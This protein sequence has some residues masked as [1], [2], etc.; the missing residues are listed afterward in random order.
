MC[1][2][3]A[4]GPRCIMAEP[5]PD[6]IPETLNNPMGASERPE[7]EDASNGEPRAPLPL[8]RGES[9]TTPGPDASAADSATAVPVTRYSDDPPTD[10]HTE[11]LAP[12]SFSSFASSL[13]IPGYEI[14][15]KLGEG[16]M[17]V[18]YRARQVRANR[19]VALKMVRGLLTEQDRARFRIEAESV[20]RLKHD[21]IV[22]IYEIGEHEDRPYFSLEFCVGG[23]L[24]EQLEKG[25]LLPRLAA[26]LVEALARAMEAAHRKHVVHRDLKPANVLIDEKGRPK[27]S[28]FGLAK[29][30]D[31]KS[32]LTQTNAIMGT[33]SYMAPE[34]AEGQT[35]IV[36]P[37]ADVY[38]LGAIL[39]ECLTGRPPFKGISYLDTLEQV[40]QQ[41]PTPPR[42]LRRN[43][44]RDLE[45]ICLHCLKKDPAK[46]YNSAGD[47]AEDLRRFQNGESVR[48][49]RPGFLERTWRWLNQGPALAFLLLILLIVLC[50]LGAVLALVYQAGVG[51]RREVVE[52]QT[53]AGVLQIAAQ[54]DEY[55]RSYHRL[56]DLYA[57]ASSLRDYLLE[58]A[59]ERKKT[60]D[61]LR[62]GLRQRVEESGDKLLAMT[63]L[64]EHGKVMLAN[65]PKLEGE[66]LKRLS[67][68]CQALE[69][70]N[71]GVADVR[72]VSL[73]RGRPAVDVIPVIE[74][75]K[76]GTRVLGL[77]IVWIRAQALN[78]IV[79]INET[80]G[81]EG[82]VISILDEHGVRI[83]HSRPEGVLYR[84]SGPLT[85]EARR[86]VGERFRGGPEQ[87]LTETLAFPEQ[88]RRAV[89]KEPEEGMFEGRSQANGEAY[90]GVGRRLQTTPWTV[91]LLQPTGNVNRPVVDLLRR[92]ALWCVPVMLLFLGLGIPVLRGLLQGRSR[93]RR[94]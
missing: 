80:L 37:P 51:Q 35:R 33:P 62:G 34:Q 40:R 68:V 92:V 79:K 64:D 5:A 69:S 93:V 7:P 53:T 42:Q 83:A 4:F 46:R 45:T 60:G 77:V 12:A 63:V 3:A 39:Y 38:A 20:A 85:A 58:P 73:V 55:L 66:D 29:H 47:L 2:M 24:A 84:P 89:A 15:E 31:E 23:D 43:V 86:K 10:P 88:Y 91:F 48:V 67:C 41:E 11:T 18:V 50:N 70:G 78:D 17:G 82:G 14:L 44:P 25:P 28:D 52:A 72:F 65:R 1:V 36:G 61:R 71:G 56:A 22:Q 32:G 54:V 59:A 8:E 26:R 13:L 94:A 30:T 19:I 57:R 74:P 21:N 87:R 75:I 9:K 6:S 76:N 16:G 90:V 49:R 27:V 81:G